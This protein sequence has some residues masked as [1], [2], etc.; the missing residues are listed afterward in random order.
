VGFNAVKGVSQVAAAR[1][2]AQSVDAK[3]K[4]PSTSSPQVT[5][6]GAEIKTNFLKLKCIQKV[7]QYILQ[8]YK[9]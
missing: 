8:I 9:K 1:T 5:A 3:A 7:M 6:F 2:V 4:L